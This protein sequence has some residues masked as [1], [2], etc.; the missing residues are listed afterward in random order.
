MAVPS[1]VKSLAGILLIIE[2]ALRLSILLETQGPTTREQAAKYQ[3]PHC[4]AA[5]VYQSGR[6]LHIRQKHMKSLT[7]PKVLSKLKCPSCDEAFNTVMAYN[8]HVKPFRCSKCQYKTS[9]KNDLGLHGMTHENS[10][11]YHCDTCNRWYKHRT[12]LQAHMRSHT[13]QY[14]CA[15]CDKTFVYPSTLRRHILQAHAAAES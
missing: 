10:T 11:T 5:Y 4:D 13:S 2:K 6:A 8:K 9:N 12:S 14:E 15:A 7:C 1:C 3:C